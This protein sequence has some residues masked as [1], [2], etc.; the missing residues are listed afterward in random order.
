MTNIESG[1]YVIDVSTELQ[2]LCGKVKNF[3]MNSNL[4]NHFQKEGFI[5][6]TITTL[7]NSEF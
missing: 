2:T 5:D 3:H 4:I 7:V 1:S 6:V